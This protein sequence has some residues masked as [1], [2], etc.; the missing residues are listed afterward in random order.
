ML[1][2]NTAREEKKGRES[3]CERKLKEWA[4][5][6][7]RGSHVHWFIDTIR[8]YFFLSCLLPIGRRQIKLSETTAKCRPQRVVLSPFILSK[9][10]GADGAVTLQKILHKSFH[11]FAPF[12]VTLPFRTFSDQGLEY[13]K[14][15]LS[16]FTRPSQ[17]WFRSKV[18]SQRSSIY[19]LRRSVQFFIRLLEDIS[20]NM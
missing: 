12:E 20:Y 16:P 11:P 10:R 7:N 2:T 5:L 3:L 4:I 18:L 6:A 14:T 1:L 15:I 19:S 8:L 17:Q 13:Y 9:V